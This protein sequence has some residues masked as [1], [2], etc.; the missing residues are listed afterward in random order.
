MHWFP[1]AIIAPILFGLVNHLDKYLLDKYF[2]FKGV[3][4]LALYSSLFGLVILPLAFF[5]SPDGIGVDLLTGI[6]LIIVGI[7]TGIA[8]ILYLYALNKEE[9]SLVV[10]FYQ[11]VP[12]FGFIFGFALLGEKLSLSQAWAGLIILFGATILSLEFVEERRLRPRW[13]ILILMLFSSMLYGFHEVLF[14]F[15]T[16][17]TSFW[18]SIFWS[19]LGL[20]MVGIALFS[21]LPDFRNDF[22]STLKENK[23][24]IVLVNLAGEAITMIGNIAILYAVLL[25]PV[26]LVQT[27]NGYQP[28]SVFIIGIFL[29]IF[30]PKIATE[31][32]GTRHLFHKIISLVIIGIGTILLY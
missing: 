6:I 1:I 30:F 22:L 27:V 20:F 24:S 28:V 32:L 2:R 8:I 31:K 11:T 16:V 12:L 9:T 18:K 26:A 14:K 15:A 29:T 3:G 23:H 4:A 13:N 19:N 17:E 25:A 10:P 21:L 5:I 7:L